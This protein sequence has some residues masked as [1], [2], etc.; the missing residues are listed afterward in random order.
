MNRSESLIY[1][2]IVSKRFK[3]FKEYIFYVRIWEKQD[4][5]YNERWN[6]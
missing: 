1:L 4:K 5:E 3:S 2:K 6:S